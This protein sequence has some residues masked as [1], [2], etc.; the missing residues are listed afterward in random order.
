M[1]ESELNDRELERTVLSVM[2]SSKLDTA[3]FAD[4]VHSTKQVK[5]ENFK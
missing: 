3:F 2:L 1:Q 4:R 5:L